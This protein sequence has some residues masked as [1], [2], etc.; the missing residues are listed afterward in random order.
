M[1]IL[2]KLIKLI[3]AVGPRE[4]RKMVSVN[5]CTRQRGQVSILDFQRDFPLDF[6][7]RGIIYYFLESFVRRTQRTGPGVD[8]RPNGI[9]Y[10]FEHVCTLWDTYPL[11]IS[12]T[13]ISVSQ[14]VKQVTKEILRGAV[15]VE[16]LLFFQ[17]F[18]RRKMV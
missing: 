2:S 9:A 10:R 6:I 4:P 18:N 17:S 5:S 12:D 16:F 15:H 11:S 13:E 7:I 3:N 14:K 8:T 1:R